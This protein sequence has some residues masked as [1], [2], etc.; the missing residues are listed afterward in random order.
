MYRNLDVLNALLYVTVNEC[1]W[2]GSHEEFGGW[3]TIYTRISR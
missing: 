2:R 1:I 3:H